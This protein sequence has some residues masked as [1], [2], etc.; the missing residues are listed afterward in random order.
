MRVQGARATAKVAPIR[1]ACRTWR[2]RRQGS[3]A[4]L[5]AT[6]PGRDCRRRARTAVEVFCVLCTIEDRDAP[7]SKQRA[8]AVCWLTCGS[9][10][11]Q[12]LTRASLKRTECVPQNSAKVH[13]TKLLSRRRP[14]S[15]AADLQCLCAHHGLWPWASIFYCK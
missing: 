15:S 12:V 11:T 10:C 8:T 7:S 13:L 14:M 3:L 2:Q 4:V 1:A 9:A 6:P 5:R